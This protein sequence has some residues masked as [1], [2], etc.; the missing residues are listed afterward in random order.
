MESRQ[1]ERDKGSQV[2]I[3]T[4]IKATRQDIEQSIQTLKAILRN[5]R[6]RY[7]AEELQNREDRIKKL[8]DNSA[9][10]Y[11]MFEY[12]NKE[13]RKKILAGS[14]SHQGGV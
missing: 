2:L 13:Q 7:A 12:Q 5:K 8:V 4:Q 3:K 10:L 11:E 9:V 1:G 6:K 14:S